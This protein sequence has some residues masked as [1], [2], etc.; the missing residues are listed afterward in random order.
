MEANIEKSEKSK[1]GKQGRS[2]GKRFETLVRK[3]LEKQGWIVVK[4]TN[5]IDFEKNTLIPAKNKF[6]PFLGRV[7]S[8]G[9]GFPDFLIFRKI[10]DETDMYEING[11]ESKLGKYLDAEEKKKAEWLLNHKVFERILIAYKKGRGQIDYQD[12]IGS[13][14]P[15]S[16]MD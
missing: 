10:N 4:W 8:E 5:Q 14:Q 2:K 12:F 16:K 11:C 3:E 9:S 7:M 1:K 6:N 13:E 15:D